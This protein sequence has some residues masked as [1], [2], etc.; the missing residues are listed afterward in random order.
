[1]SVRTYGLFLESGP[2]RRKTMVHVPGL[3]GCSANG[4]TTEAALEATPD[5]IRRFLGFLAE[6]GES[7]DPE[8][9]FRTRIVEHVTESIWLGNGDPTIVFAPDRAT[10][11]KAEI[12][13]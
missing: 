7:F 13:R 8:A 6:R 1:M 10:P 12:S 3:L 9:P 2:K 5:A 11:T 4:P